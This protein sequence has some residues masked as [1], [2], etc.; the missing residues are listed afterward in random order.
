MG[1]ITPTSK[2]YSFNGVDRNLV[3]TSA[4]VLYT[5]LLNTTDDA[6]EMW[7]STD[8]GANWS[9]LDSGNEPTGTA[10]I[11]YYAPSCAINGSDTIYVSYQKHN[12]GSFPIKYDTIVHTFLTSNDT[13]SSTNTAYDVSTTGVPNFPATSI[14]INNDQ[15]IAIAV[16]GTFTTRGSTQQVVYYG[17]NSGG[18]FTSLNIGSALF[19]S[20]IISVSEAKPLIASV[21]ATVGVDNLRV[22]IINTSASSTSY[23]PLSSGDSLSTSNWSQPQIIEAAD[24]TLYVVFVDDDATSIS[25]VRRYKGTAFSTWST[26]KKIDSSSAW[27]HA[28]AAARGYSKGHADINVLAISGGASANE[29]VLNITSYNDFNSDNPHSS[30]L[31]DTG[32]KLAQIKSKYSTYY[33]H[34]VTQ[35]DYVFL[36]D[37]STYTSVYYGK[38]SLN[39]PV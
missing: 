15:V 35:L 21:L 30:S 13:W 19:P 17:N 9:H 18:S 22:T 39:N 1:Q 25:Y 11:D 26:I 32:K 3:R 36:H 34:G 16:A 10:S 33:N 4:G 28:T 37:D 2:T 20:I 27:V 14:A 23:F 8:G 6:V 29:N 12:T 7:K 5:V 31:A 24:G 38:L